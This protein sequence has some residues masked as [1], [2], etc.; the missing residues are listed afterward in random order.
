[1]GTIENIFLY[2]LILGLGTSLHCIG[3]C[4]PI[5]VSLGISGYKS[6]FHIQNIVY[7]LGRATTY[8]FLGAIIGGF[9]EVLQLLVYQNYI[10]IIAGAL[11]IILASFPVISNRWMAQ[12][13]ILNQLLLPIKM[14]LSSLMQRKDLG[15]RY[16][17]GIFNGF[18]PCG[19]VYIALAG[20]IGAGSVLKSAL[21][22][23]LF[24]LGTIP[25]MYAVVLVGNSLQGK[26]RNK[27][28]QW[29]PVIS[30]IIGILFIL[31][32]LQ[33]GIPFLSPPKKMLEEK[34]EK[35]Q[36]SANRSLK[37]TGEATFVLRHSD[38]F[39]KEYHRAPQIL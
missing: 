21:F 17:T 9:S 22:M 38:F 2:A 32:G 30:I 34:I 19:A 1:M 15:S 5:A 26:V 33:L 14:R 27:L 29:M 3:M 13:N 31:R 12:N 18:L 7:Q 10:S 37:R 16:L 11:I 25:L 4:G 36:P 28:Y 8:A 24:G 20:A 39:Q 35:I 23:F 6:Q